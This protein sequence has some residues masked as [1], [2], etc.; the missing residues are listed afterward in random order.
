MIF[1]LPR[2][3]KALPV[4]YS[5]WCPPRCE[6]RLFS[7]PM[8]PNRLVQIQ[9]P[10]N[11]TPSNPIFHPTQ[12]HPIPSY[13]TPFST[14][15]SHPIQS[16]P[17]PSHPI[18]SHP[19]PSHPIPSHPIPPNPNPSNPIISQSRPIPSNPILSNPIPS[20]PIL[21]HL[22]PSTHPNQLSSEGQGKERPI[23]RRQ[24]RSNTAQEEKRPSL[25]GR[26]CPLE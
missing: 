6:I 9:T 14:I 7:S 10:S 13:P 22:I 2:N 8:Y 4:E 3:A 15:P 1:T 26:G 19:I 18:L 21:P 23:A 25:D 17:I 20:H 5:A 24:Q 12:S 11:S 16:H